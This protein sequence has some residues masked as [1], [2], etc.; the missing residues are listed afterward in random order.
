MVLSMLIGV[1][2]ATA[3]AG[4]ALTE[5]RVPISVEDQARIVG[6]RDSSTPTLEA[7]DRRRSQLWTLAFS[8]LVC[9]A[10][11]VALLTSGGSDHL[12]VANRV[13][14]R[15]G[16]VAL[17]V[18]LAV[19][20]MEKELHLRRLAR[21]LIDERVL[22]AAMS[23]RL[24]ELAALY[25]AGKAMNSV[26]VIEDVLK[27]ILA[28]AFELLEASSGS[29]MLLA[30]DADTLTVVCALG[31]ATADGA[32]AKLGEGIAGKVAQ[33]REP[34]LIQGQVSVGRALAT[35]SAVSVPLIHR[36]ELFG[37]LNLN[38]STE[39][40][41][42]E[43]DLRAVS[44]FA[45]HAAMAIANARLY[46]AERELRRWRLVWSELPG[47]LVQPANPPTSRG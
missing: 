26:L 27:L 34:L 15:V 8:A 42:T 12:G 20:V 37:V 6:I 39:R 46:E 1:R 4:D 2:T 22:G 19:Y 25:E 40:V 18:A 7:V 47:V 14:F 13:P 5:R 11:S 17:V 36:D 43:Y 32:R 38:G 44:L 45:E 35:D 30:N 10:V 21:A 31:N 3:A 41:Y 16:T 29:I 33:Q 28:S 23:N 24:K 9:L